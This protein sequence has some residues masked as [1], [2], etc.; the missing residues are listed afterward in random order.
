M[1]QEF[2]VDGFEVVWRV[3]G[4]GEGGYGGDE[5]RFQGGRGRVAELR[6]ERVAYLGE[7]AGGFPEF[8]RRS[9]RCLRGW[10]GA[11]RLGRARR[12]RA[13]S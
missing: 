13:V 10:R 3:C 9:V 12:R 4:G 5:R 7:A 2:R 8:C 1:R 6:Q 11:Y